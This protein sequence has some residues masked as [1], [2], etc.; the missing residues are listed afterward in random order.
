[1]CGGVLAGIFGFPLSVYPPFSQ[2][3]RRLGGEKK[4]KK[5][6]PYLQHKQRKTE[7]LVGLRPANDYCFLGNAFGS[8]KFTG[9]HSL[10]RGGL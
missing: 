3:K 9:N 10:A 5:Q 1:V 7:S 2:T 6:W 4:K 8:S